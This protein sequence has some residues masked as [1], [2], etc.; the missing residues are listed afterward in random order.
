MYIER[1]NRRLVGWEV[2]SYIYELFPNFSLLNRRVAI[3]W[4]LKGRV[5]TSL[6]EGATV[7]LTLR[8]VPMLQGV[9]KGPKKISR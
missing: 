8:R 4:P 3:N 2:G 5:K 6:L 1:N 7:C 9:L